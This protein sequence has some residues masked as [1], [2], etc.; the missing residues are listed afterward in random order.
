MLPS[1]VHGV[2]IAD[3]VPAA[4]AKARAA[5]LARRRPELYGLL[6]LHR[7]PT[8]PAATPTPRPVE[9]AVEGGDPAAAGVTAW[10][11]PPRGGLAVLPAL[12][13]D[14]PDRPAADYQRLA[15]PT[16]GPSEAALIALARQGGGYVA[17]SYPE[18]DGA[19]VFHTV[20]L[21]APDGDIIARYRATHLPPDQTWATPGDRFV[22][23]PTPLGRIALAVGE[24]LAV[25]E[26]FGIYSAE[27]A[28]IVAAPSGRWRG[29]LLATDPKL[30]NTPYPPGTPFAPW[31]AAALGQFWVAAAGWQLHPEPASWLLGPDPVIAT[32]P[33]GA[34]PGQRVE[35]T[36]TAPWVGTWINQGQLIGGQEPLSTLPLVLP[37]DSACLA[38]WRET[39]ALSADC[40]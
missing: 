10:R 7:A 29:P 15:E 30:F 34:P 31:A 1:G 36:V 8:D 18:R 2:L 40:R 6:A 17:G 3:I 35:A 4:A 27:R 37:A 14:G 21:A 26:V 11:P 24:E 13:R 5:L 38:A 19:A 32:A 25:P 12:F 39:D 16:G 20:A 22:V 33:R 23:A 9:L 28:D